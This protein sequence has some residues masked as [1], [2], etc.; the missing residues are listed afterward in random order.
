MHQVVRT[1]AVSFGATRTEVGTI[2]AL[3][4]VL[5]QLERP[6]MTDLEVCTSTAASKSNFAKW[7]RRVRLAM[8]KPDAR[9]HVSHQVFGGG[10]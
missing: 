2:K 1:L 10:S 6:G 5:L 4:A 3:H 8:Q 7:K 9:L